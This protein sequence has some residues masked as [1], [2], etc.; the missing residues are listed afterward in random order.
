[1]VQ[2]IQLFQS[3]MQTNPE[4]QAFIDVEQIAVESVRLMGAPPSIIRSKD[5]VEEIQ[6]AQQERVQQQEQLNQGE[7]IA[8]IAEKAAKAQNEG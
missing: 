8:G 5:E 3:L 6:A 7:Q 4:A 1:M 2:T